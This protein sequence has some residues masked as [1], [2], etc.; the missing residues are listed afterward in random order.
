[1]AN[2]EVKNTEESAKDTMPE[3]ILVDLGKQR[4]K[5]VRRLR[6]GRGRLMG[7][8]LDAVDDLRD[9]EEIAPDAQV[10]VAIVRERRRRRKYPFF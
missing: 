1:M 3:P 7:N 6:K 8:V 10:V 5:R 9:R 4:R 2:E